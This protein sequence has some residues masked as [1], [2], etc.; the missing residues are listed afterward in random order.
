MDELCERLKDTNR[1]NCELVCT[2]N[3]NPYYFPLYRFDSSDNISELGGFFVYKAVIG[4]DDEVISLSPISISGLCVEDILKSCDIL[5]S[6]IAIA[7]L[8][9][10]ESVKVHMLHENTDT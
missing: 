4:K 3:G 1:L 9:R 2:R 10:Y 7:D 5:V 6:P 8:R